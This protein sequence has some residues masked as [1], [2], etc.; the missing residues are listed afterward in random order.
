MSK[1][2]GHPSLQCAEYPNYLARRATHPNFAIATTLA[3]SNVSSQNT[4]VMNVKTFIEFIISI[5]TFL[6]E[7]A[8]MIF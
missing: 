2:T 7:L 6:I 4:R 8:R 5:A 3:N 1:K